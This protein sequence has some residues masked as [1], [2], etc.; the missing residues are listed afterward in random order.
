MWRMLWSIENVLCHLL[1][2]VTCRH[3][4]QKFQDKTGYIYSPKDSTD[5][6][7]EMDRR[8]DVVF[9]GKTWR[10]VHHIKSG[11]RDATLLRI[12][13][14]VDRGGKRLI[15]GWLGDHLPTLGTSKNS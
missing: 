5:L 14:D 1:M 8:R 3:P 4:G 12:Y 9:E 6:P 7:P 11:S 15:I 10:I 2:D 13:F